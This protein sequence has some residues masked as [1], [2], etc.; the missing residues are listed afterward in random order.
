MLSIDRL[1][2]THKAPETLLQEFWLALCHL[3]KDDLVVVASILLNTRS[4]SLQTFT[5]SCAISMGV[6]FLHPEFLHGSR[7]LLLHVLACPSLIAGDHLVGGDEEDTCERSLLAIL[8]R[9]KRQE[10]CH[11]ML[12]SCNWWHEPRIIHS[13]Q[14]C[15]DVRMLPEPFF[16]KD[17]LRFG[18]APC[19]RRSN[20]IRGKGERE[21]H[22][23]LL[24]MQ[25]RET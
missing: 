6:P 13:C 17:R 9:V 18:S 24:R 25:T 11:Q 5:A 19:F 20:Q 22:L 3:L 2:P 7:D 16:H 8:G 10:Q 1:T 4:N 15:S 12:I 14:L 21:T 23:F